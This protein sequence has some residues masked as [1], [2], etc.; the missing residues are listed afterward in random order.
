MVT[1]K[2]NLLDGDDKMQMTAD[3]AFDDKNVDASFKMDVT[4]DGESV[5]MNLSVLST[6]EDNKSNTDVKLSVNGGG[7]D[8][9]I[10]LKLDGEQT[11]GDTTASS[12]GNM[13]LSMDVDGVEMALN[14]SYTAKAETGADGVR[15]ETNADVG[16]TVMGMEI[17]LCSVKAVTESCDAMA[18]LAEGESVHPAAMSDE[19]LTAYGEEIVTDAQTAAMVLIQ[20]LPTSVL[21][22]MMGN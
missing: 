12:M 4:E 10:A 15:R 5:V 20:N 21:Q 14:G 17:P 16:L 8:V 7:E 11:P 3:A 2:A 22:L 1:F 9:S 13:S 6:N 18:S 19:E